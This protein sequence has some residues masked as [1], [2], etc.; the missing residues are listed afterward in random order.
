LATYLIDQTVAKL[1]LD[2][3]SGRGT[4]R[5]G[6][7]AVVFSGSCAEFNHSRVGDAFGGRHG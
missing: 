2:G 6:Q 3:R 1:T 4:R 5:A 7:H